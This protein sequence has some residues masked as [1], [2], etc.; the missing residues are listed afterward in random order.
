MTTKMVFAVV[1]K[2]VLANLSHSVARVIILTS[3]CISTHSSL[4]GIGS[5]TLTSADGEILATGGE[6]L[7]PSETKTFQLP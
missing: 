6:W 7:G 3:P 1:G 5:Y 4:R 2:I